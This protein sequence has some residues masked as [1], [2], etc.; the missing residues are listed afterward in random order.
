MKITINSHTVNSSNPLI[1][2]YK[3]VMDTDNGLRYDFNSFDKEQFTEHSL[4][5][6]DNESYTVKGYFTLE[7]ENAPNNVFPSVDG[8]GSI[9]L[10]NA[11][12]LKIESLSIPEGWLNTDC[13]SEIFTCWQHDCRTYYEGQRVVVW[14]VHNNYHMCPVATNVN[15]NEYEHF[16]QYM[17]NLF[18]DILSN[19]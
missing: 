5:L 6:V 1:V 3:F 4:L 12:Q 15:D 8:N 9:D 2:S 18:S 10:G 13:L 14:F 17:T 11:I 7:T 16:S 19:H